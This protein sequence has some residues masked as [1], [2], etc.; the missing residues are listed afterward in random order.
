MKLKTKIILLVVLAVVCVAAL[1]AGCSIGEPNPIEGAY[2]NGMNRQTVVYYAN[3]GYFNG[4]T[5]TKTLELWY[6]ENGNVLN[7]SKQEIAGKS[8]SNV[9]KKLVIDGWLYAELDADGKPIF[10]DEEKTVV[11]PSDR[12]VEFPL[13]IQRDQHLHICANWVYDVLLDYV[14]VIDGNEKVKFEDDEKEYVT[15]DVIQSVGFG[16][17]SYLNVTESDL[18]TGEN[19]TFYQF[20]S[21]KEC[22]KVFEGKVLRPTEENAEN[23]K[24]YAK[25]ISGVYKMVRTAQDFANIFRYQNRTHQ[26][27]IFND[28]DCSGEAIMPSN[29]NEFKGSIYGNNKKI[30]NITVTESGITNAYKRSLFGTLTKDSYIKDLTFEN[31][32]INYGLRDR[33]KAGI[34][35]YA[36]IYGAAEGAVIENFTVTGLNFTVT[37]PYGDMSNDSYSAVENI[38][39]EN[40][41]YNTSNYLFG[42]V[43][44]DT[45]FLARFSGLKVINP[46]ITVNSI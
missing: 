31:V 41:D 18:R 6:K 44:A 2:D 37:I 20:Y 10:L 1:A 7:I 33:S 34:E 5:M 4:N 36:L 32:N 13:R 45:E 30:S 39:Y 43:S 16:T 9:D 46:Q 38:P 11:K 22:T 24:V 8:V 12:Q 42:G 17:A 21:D 3:G 29:G 14:L 35:L 28:I 27:Y 23:P 19:A 26:Y 15:G 40:G 25:Y